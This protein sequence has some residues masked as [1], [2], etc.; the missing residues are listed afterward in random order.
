M[1]DVM[2]DLNGF[3]GIVPDEYDFAHE[4][5]LVPK[6]TTIKVHRGFNRKLHNLLCFK[7]DNTL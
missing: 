6:G 2:I 1:R 3:S 7:M 4:M 5:N